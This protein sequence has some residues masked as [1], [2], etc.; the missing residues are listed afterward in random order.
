MAK[1]IMWPQEKATLKCLPVLA[2][3]D[4]YRW[5]FLFLHLQMGDCKDTQEDEGQTLPPLTV[6][7]KTQEWGKET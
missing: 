3:K 4:G 5:K 7:Q 2:E 1:K 6:C